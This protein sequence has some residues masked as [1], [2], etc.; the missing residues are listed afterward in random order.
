MK[1]PVIK[2][3][4]LHLSLRKFVLSAF[5][6]LLALGTSHAQILYIT[7]D[8]NSSLGSYDLT[9]GAAINALL[10]QNLDAP[11][12]VAV[13]GD[14]IYVGS[15]LNGPRIGK[16]NL[17]GSAV[18]T[19]F[20]SGFRS[21]GIAVSGANLYATA[22]IDGTIGHYNS[23]TGAAINAPLVSGLEAAN[24]YA[25]TLDKSGNM[26]VANYGARTVSKYSAEGTLLEPALIS[27]MG[28]LFGIAID[29]NGNVYTTDFDG[30]HIIKYN[31]ATG[32][33]G[34]IRSGLSNPTGIVFNDGKLY[35]GEYTDG[36]IG[37][38]DLNGGVLNAEW[39]TGV[40]GVTALAIPEPSTV[41][42]L[43]FGAAGFIL[44]VRKRRSVAKL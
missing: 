31:V 4:R 25:I 10:I 32:E 34:Y 28:G 17:D 43:A 22:Y 23:I 2:N 8:S 29:D 16:Y 27:A 9:T 24:P 38:Y 39:I 11:Y 37:V 6:G 15:L 20:I 26:Y 12:S 13:S 41:A 42:L 19:S 40:S 18:N 7:R 36:V 33:F 30:G 21:N 44:Q 3:S 14:S 1:P 5:L 35:V